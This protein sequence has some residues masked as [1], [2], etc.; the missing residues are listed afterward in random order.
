[1]AYLGNSLTVQQYAPQVAYFSG[2]GS[3]TAFTLPTAVVSASQIIVVVANV[4]QNPSS[5]YT[6]SSTTLTFTSAPPTGT[7]NVWVEYTSLQTNLVSP[8][9]GSVSNASFGSLT[10]IPFVTGGNIGAGDSTIMKNRIINGAMVIDQRNAGASVT[11]ASGEYTLDRWV[12]NASQ[13]SKFTVQQNAGPTTSGFTYAVK[14]TV[15]SAVSVGASDA[16]TFSQIIEGYNVADLAWGTASAKTVTVSFWVNSSLTG[17][18]SFSFTNSGARSYLGTYTVNS[19]NTWEYKTVTIAG[20]TSGTWNTTNGTGL[21]VRFNL[22]SGSSSTTSAGSWQ[23]GNYTGATGDI[24]V[25]G[26]NG[27][28]F[29][30]TGVQLEVGSSATGFEYRQYGQELALCQR[31]FYQASKYLGLPITSDTLYGPCITFPV[32]MRATPT[33]NSGSVFIP[34]TGSAG[35]VAI[36]TGVTGIIASPDG[37]DLYNSANNW[38][39]NNAA[40]ISVTAGFSAEL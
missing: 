9:A 30:I 34:R 13:A 29:Y 2:N 15:A 24:S 39:V 27:A 14:L 16:F 22:G 40:Q 4:P 10:S 23:A 8:V 5:A 6:V 25:V 32:T 35:T 21:Y 1:M 3:T 19:A 17:Q 38:T 20:D 37:V 26:T 12:Y 28:T 7:N 36:S 31:Y 33:L 18:N 11:P